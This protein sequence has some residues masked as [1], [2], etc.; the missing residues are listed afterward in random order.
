MR[1]IKDADYAITV[2]RLYRQYGIGKFANW[3]KGK[4]D[5]IHREEVVR[6]LEFAEVR[7]IAKRQIEYDRARLEELESMVAESEG[8]TVE[9]L[10]NELNL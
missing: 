6:S 7:E 2:W 9:K 8:K 10:L 3:L 5:E 1:E 4:P